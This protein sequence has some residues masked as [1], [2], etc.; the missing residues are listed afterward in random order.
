MGAV[1]MVAAS[2]LA[3]IA[4]LGVDATRPKAAAAQLVSAI[5][6]ADR[7]VV[8]TFPTQLH[9]RFDRPVRLATATVFVDGQRIGVPQTQREGESAF[10][11]PLSL[12]R[13]GEYTVEWEAIAETGTVRT[14]WSTFRFAPNGTP[15]PVSTIAPPSTSLAIGTTP[16]PSPLS[17]AP[18]EAVRQTRTP[19]TRKTQR[20]DATA[21][22]APTTASP[23]AFASGVAR[24]NGSPAA[25]AR[26]RPRPTK[27]PTSTAAVSASTRPANVR[28][29]V[30][31]DTITLGEPINVHAND[32]MASG[33]VGNYDIAGASK[34]AQ[35]AVP[36]GTTPSMDGLGPQQQ[37][38]PTATL[39]RKRSIHPSA[40]A[41]AAA[42]A[43]VSI[44]LIGVV[45]RLSRR[46]RTS[47][48]P[49]PS[50]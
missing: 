47:P 10:R 2:G 18:R 24:V 45:V 20:S 42:L 31:P 40:A 34:I 46:R 41:L 33:K 8:S 6:P 12:G 17:G 4:M 9:V 28:R 23:L 26:S 29:T 14:V 32:D 13:P 43:A 5:E 16:Q 39:V 1:P 44:G 27:P 7:V 25:I 30:T 11:A 49:T 21:E 38:P 35:G 22:V 50:L 19:R 48:R 15:A 36:F 37:S 3:S